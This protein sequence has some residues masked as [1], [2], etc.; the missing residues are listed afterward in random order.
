MTKMKSLEDFGWHDERPCPPWCV[1]EHDRSTSYY[2]RGETV[3]VDSL[4]EVVDGEPVIAEIALCQGVQYDGQKG[5]GWRTGRAFVDVPYV[6]DSLTPNSARALAEALK[7]VADQ[8]ESDNEWRR[9]QGYVVRPEWEFLY[10]MKSPRP[11]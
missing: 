3:F 7:A 5:R 10:D 1:W 8:A 11:R 9:A 2:H 4:D 6:A